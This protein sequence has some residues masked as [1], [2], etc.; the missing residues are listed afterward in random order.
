M[1]AAYGQD[2]TG[3]G[4]GW[5]GRPRYAAD[6]IAALLWR[7][8]L[9]IVAVFGAIFLLGALVAMRMEQTYAA[10]SSLLVRIGQEYVYQPRAGE[11]AEGA[12]PEVA[13][14]I[15]SEK[16][17]LTS[18]QLRTRVIER[19]G[20]ERVFPERAARFRRA[21]PERRVSLTA[22]GADD[23]GRG[24]DVETAPEQNVIRLTYKAKDARLAALILNTMID[25]YLVYRREVFADDTLPGVTRQR[26]AFERQLAQ[27]DAA[28]QNF[29]IENGIGDFEAERTSMNTLYTSLNETRFRAQARLSEVRGRLGGQNQ[30]MRGLQP[31]ISLYRDVDDSAARRL[32]TLRVQRDELLTRYRADAQPV[33]ELDRQIEQFEAAVAA[34][35]GVG[36]QLRRVGVNPVYQ[37]IQTERLQLQAEAASLQQTVGAVDRQLGEIA[38]RRRQLS[39]LEPR[40]QQLTR[41]RAVLDA[42]VR[43]FAEREQQSQAA[44]AVA[45]SANDNIK[46]VERAVPP[47]EGAS[48]R[49]PLLAL[50][51][52][53]A[54]ATALAAALTKIFLGRGFATPG[55]AGRTL[56]LPVLTTAPAVRA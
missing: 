6:D 27:A 34:G 9:L 43:A 8:R 25:E 38:A 33:R 21:S 45:L 40:H 2:R 3:P 13:E 31:E 14:V 51:F 29:L 39:A 37:T 52:M 1:S 48:L 16:E 30:A 53:F 46:V 15:Q 54:G 22:K 20:Y 55:S 28:Y 47:V 19:L 10:R 36:E 49:L 50:S 24:L 56:D 7:E 18:A 35:R 32:V 17:I 12:A 44:Q 11:V 23:L 4:A 41:E 5:S 26:E 42:N